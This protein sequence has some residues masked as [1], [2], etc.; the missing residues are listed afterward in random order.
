[1]KCLVIVDSGAIA[2]WKRECIE[3]L[4]AVNDVEVTLDDPKNG[5][6]GVVLDLREAS[7]PSPSAQ[8][9]AECWYFC[10]AEGRPLGKL[11]AAAEIACGS[12]TFTIALRARR[13]DGPDVVLRSGRFKAL[14][15]YSRSLRV[16]LGECMRWPVICLAAP[17][18]VQ[19]I[20]AATASAEA[21]RFSRVRFLLRQF[22]LFAAHAYRHLFVDTR[23]RVGVVR[24]IPASFLSEHYLPDVEW[25]RGQPNF[26][27]DPFVLRCNDGAFILGERLDGVTRNGFIA[28]VA[29]D[30][31]GRI[32]D[33]RTVLRG[34]SHL[35]YPYVFK[36]GDDWY[37]VPESADEHRIVLYRAEDFPYSWTRAATLID[38][39]AACDSTILRHSGLWW[40][41]C[42]DR[43]RD[44]TLNLFLFYAR[45]LTGPWTPHRANPVKT[46]V[47]S[48]RPAGMP[49]VVDGAL[50]RPGQ[51]CA[52]SYGS[53]ISFNR[54]R[55]LNELEYVEEEVSRSTLSGVHTIS[56]ADGIVAIDSKRDVLAAPSLVA[57]RIGNLA[58]R[59]LRMKHAG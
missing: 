30:T 9:E 23:W 46:D 37:M 16:A 2:R 25:L 1:M 6:A 39:I 26:F 56:Y 31:E 4:R 32:V 3:R 21:V 34:S 53:A 22:R 17:A 43:S 41:F 40:L 27:A 42:T 19:R 57:R 29:V 36:D 24:D 55:T 38:G 35:S 51:D 5:W 8:T 13:K 12:P 33:R 58:G 18:S 20:E 10:D 7:V 14:Y 59:V 47:R 54:V 28:G 11:P 44:S 48:A 50:Y 45:E 15:S 49:F 52:E